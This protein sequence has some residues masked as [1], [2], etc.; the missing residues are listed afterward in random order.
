MNDSLH[1][2]FIQEAEDNLEIL[3]NCIIA[4]E[5][6]P[7]D[8]T[9]INEAFRAIH[10]IKGGAGLAGFSGIQD[11]THILED[12]FECIR[13]GTIKAKEHHV[14]IILRA[15]DII[16]IMIENIKDGKDS[17]SNIETAEILTE[18]KN[19]IGVSDEATDKHSI[20]EKSDKINLFYLD[21]TYYPEIFNTGID[22]AMFLSDLRQI[23]N[24]LFTQI[25]TNEFPGLHDYDPEKLYISWKL[26]YETK[27]NEKDI[28]DIF[29]FVIDES[30]IAI[31]N[32]TALKDDP[33]LLE[34]YKI[35]GK[36]INDFIPEIAS[37]DITV[38][39]KGNT[40]GTDSEKKSTTPEGK[41]LFGRRKS[42]HTPASYIRVQTEKL[43]NIFNTVS[44]LLISQARL[45]MLTE[46]YEDIIPEGFGT[47]TDSFKNIT[48]LLQEQ[49]TSLRMMSLGST[50]DRFKRVVR[51]MA[52]ERGKKVKLEL[53]GQD[54]ELDKNMIEKL[55]DPLKHLVRNCIDHGIET[56]EE[57]IKKGKTAEGILKLSAYIENGKVIIEVA[58]DGAGINKEKLLSKAKEKKLVS[59]EHQ[60]SDGEVLNLIFNPGLST[61]DKITD[62]SGRGVGMDVV[63]NSIIELHGNIEISSKENEGTTFHLHL[64]LTLAILDGM[65]IRIGNEKYIIPTLSILEIFRPQSEHLKTISGKGEVVFFRGDY[66]PLIRLHNVFGTKE[67]IEAP[68]GGELIVIYSGG[69]KAAL[70][71][72]TV[73]EQ[74][75]IVLKSLQKNFRKVDNIS[76]ATILGNGDVALIIDIQNLLINR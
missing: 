71:V 25:D 28:S 50:F 27:K 8:D 73:L 75:Q 54:T 46:E 61:A 47:V 5:K 76:S 9:K 36:T 13:S 43:E 40:V 68:T 10:S 14:S 2:I 53:S 45:N 51:D 38:A 7:D 26:F 57:R 11:F 35:D 15:L 30:E 19:L 44:E 58:D 17:N 70:L 1:D 67:Y 24:I 23:G 29:C 63:K 74:F 34:S 41:I 21:L 56:E 60:L 6:N 16:K 49:I 22:P 32:I 31:T 66:V 62:L 3:E 65:L 72:D 55:N 42:D 52:S 20:S 12:L 18:I 69:V 64:P 48:T 59:P 4:I 39:E 33:V 37:N